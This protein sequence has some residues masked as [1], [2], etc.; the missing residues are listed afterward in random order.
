MIC[1]DAVA[2]VLLAAVPGWP[3]PAH[4]ER[5]DRPLPCRSPPRPETPSWCSTPEQKSTARMGSL[6]LILLATC[7]PIL[8]QFLILRP[9]NANCPVKVHVA[10]AANLQLILSD[11]L[12]L[13]TPFLNQAL[14]ADTIYTDMVSA[15]P[16][17][18]QLISGGAGE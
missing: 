13:R 1:L 15:A 7:R 9:K 11:H 6:L 3:G 14:S 10:S 4:R 5:A 8:R 12:N 17:Q 18:L 2:G 16:E